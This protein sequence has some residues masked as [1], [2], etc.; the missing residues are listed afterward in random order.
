[1][2][3]QDQKRLE[4][5][6][7]LR[8]EQ[9][10]TLQ[11]IADSLDPKISRERVRQLIGNSGKYVVSQKKKEIALAH[12]E[13]TNKELGDLLGLIPTSVNKYRKGTRH[14][15]FGGNAKLAYEAEEYISGVLNEHGIGHTLVPR[16]TGHDVELESGKCAEISS[17][18][19][20]WAPPSLSSYP[21]YRFRI[22]NRLADYYIC[23]IMTT[24]TV[25]VIP[26]CD[27]PKY[28][29]YIFWPTKKKSKFA[30][31]LNNFDLLR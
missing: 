22:C 14:V 2:P 28:Y 23:I 21:Y 26:S 31:Y 15:M 5:I 30:K 29:I 12:P 3:I 24:K 19:K 9:G 6:K 10:W 11:Q 27:V 13:L 18:Y 17:A 4:C 20:T 25:F 8:F 7:Q 16:N 1:M